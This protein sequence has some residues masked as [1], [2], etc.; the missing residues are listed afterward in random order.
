MVGVFRRSEYRKYPLVFYCIWFAV[1]G[2]YACYWVLVNE[3]AMLRGVQ[4]YPSLMTFL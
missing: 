4:R 2:S 1:D 3:A